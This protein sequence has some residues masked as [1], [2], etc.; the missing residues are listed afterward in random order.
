MLPLVT[1]TFHNTQHN[2]SGAARHARSTLSASLALHELFLIIFIYILSR[3]YSLLVTHRE[4]Y[5]ESTG[6]DLDYC[7]H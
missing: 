3:S 6:T 2:H 7:H 5:K 1:L 4:R